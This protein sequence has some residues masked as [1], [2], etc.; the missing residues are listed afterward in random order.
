MVLMI[1]NASPKEAEPSAF[2]IES[3]EASAKLEK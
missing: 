2:V 1:S 3:L